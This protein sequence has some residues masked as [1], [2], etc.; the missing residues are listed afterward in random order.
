MK[1]RARARG[2]AG[3]WTRVASC[4]YLPPGRSAVL[5][6]APLPPVS[7]SPEPGSGARGLDYEHDFI[8]DSHSLLFLNSCPSSGPPSPSRT[9]LLRQRSCHWSAAQECPPLCVEDAV[10]LARRGCHS[11]GGAE[12]CRRA[13]GGVRSALA[14]AAGGWSSSGAAAP[15]LRPSLLASAAGRDTHRERGRTSFPAKAAARA[16]AA[17]WRD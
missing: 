11:C 16:R 14:A 5:T 6:V 1:D 17:L 15:L 10:L 2:A 12:V 4:I 9:P 8:D 7:E 13:R 3:G